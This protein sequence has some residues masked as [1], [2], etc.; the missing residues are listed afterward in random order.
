MGAMRPETQILKRLQED[1]LFFYAASSNIFKQEFEMFSSSEPWGYFESSKDELRAIKLAHDSG[2]F[3]FS[4]FPAFLIRKC[5]FC[6][7]C[8]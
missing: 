1:S 4:A 7:N 3:K 6:T 8:L 2:Y 5:M